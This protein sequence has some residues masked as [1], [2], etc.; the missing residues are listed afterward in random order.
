MISEID[1]QVFFI[2]YL[3][4]TYLYSSSCRGASQMCV[5]LYQCLLLQHSVEEHANFY[6]PLLSYH[7]VQHYI[8]PNVLYMK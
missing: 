2:G 3:Q 8:T 7:L 5:Y 6:S 1:H 4:C